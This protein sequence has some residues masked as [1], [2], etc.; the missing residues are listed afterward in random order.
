MNKNTIFFLFL[1][2]SLSGCQ[3]NTK[4]SGMDTPSPEGTKQV[5]KHHTVAQTPMPAAKEERPKPQASAS[6]AQERHSISLTPYEQLTAHLLHLGEKA[7]EEDRLLTPEDDNANLYFQA[8]LGRDPGNYRA[9]Q[10]VV[11]IVDTYCQW[12][13]KMAQERNYRKAQ[14]YLDS[15]RSAN[16]QDPLIQEMDTRIEN[17]KQKRKTVQEHAPKPTTPSPEESN[18]D[19]FILPEDLFSLS[20]DE[21]LAKI[22]PI[23]NKVENEQRPI[24]I[25]WPNDKEARLIYQIINSHVSEFRVRAMIY[26]SAKYMV[27][28]QQD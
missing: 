28:L 1:V 18:P 24:D 12:A 6:V 21:I 2:F 19:A 27:K 16:P 17:L 15:A 22:Q 20:D 25:Y 8:V 13:W 7:L 14:R 23:V 9:I 5:A 10:G 26:H 4:L 3:E 11:A